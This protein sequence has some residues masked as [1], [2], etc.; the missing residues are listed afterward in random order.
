[1][2][3]FYIIANVLCCYL[4]LLESSNGCCTGGVVDNINK[5]FEMSLYVLTQHHCVL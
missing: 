1:M 3:T 5:H 2:K 4:N